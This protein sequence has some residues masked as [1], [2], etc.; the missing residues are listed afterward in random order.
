MAKSLGQ[1]RVAAAPTPR[2]VVSVSVSETLFA[3]SAQALAQRAGGES[4]DDLAKTTLLQVMALRSTATPLAID[5]Y[6]DAYNGNPGE[7]YQAFNSGLDA[8]YQQLH[9]AT[10]SASRLLQNR[11]G[12]PVPGSSLSAT[13]AY[14][15]DAGRA[16]PLAVGWRSAQ[17]EIKLL[18]WVSTVRNKAVQHRDQNG[19]TSN[20]AIVL[21][22]GFALLRKP[23]DIEP[24]QLRATRSFLRGLVRR[25]RIALDPEVGDVEIIT[26]L[27]LVSHSLV[28]HSLGEYDRARELVAVAKRHDLIVSQPFL[29][30]RDRSLAAL[31]RLIPHS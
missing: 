21:T 19:Y 8:L 30:N 31:L 1:R 18:R 20:R 11:V 25:Y 15:A 23:L 29:A 27:D 13:D 10:E 3:C 9:A 24:V 2:T 16:H 5:H 28:E 12:S 22:D 14:F 7:V 4:V 26:Y 6:Q 17:R